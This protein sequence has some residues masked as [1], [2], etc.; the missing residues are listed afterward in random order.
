[1]H[2]VVLNAKLTRQSKLRNSLAFDFAIVAPT[3]NAAEYTLKK[4][5]RRG[6][7]DNPAAAPCST[8]V[9]IYSGSA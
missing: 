4:L 8:T 1:M 6:K 7:E 5:F 2:L 3:G 9:R